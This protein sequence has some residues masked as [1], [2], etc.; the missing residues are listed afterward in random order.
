MKCFHPSWRDVAEIIAEFT[1]ARGMTWVWVA[2]PGS[3]RPLTFERSNMIWVG[4]EPNEDDLHLYR[5][6]KS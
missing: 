3:S 5:M 1:D 4:E 2:P 6:G